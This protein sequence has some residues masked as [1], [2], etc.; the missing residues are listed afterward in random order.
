M[1]NGLRPRGFIR[2]NDVCFRR[3]Q[4]LILVGTLPSALVP[5]WEVLQLDTQNPGLKGVQAPVV[6]LHVVVVLLCLSMIANHANLLCQF[7]VVSRDNSRFAARAQILSGI[8]AKG[9]RLADR[10]N[11]L[12][13]LVTFGEI[14]SAVG[15]AGI[16]DD[17]QA[18]A[19]GNLLDCVHLGTLSIQVYGDH[20]RYRPASL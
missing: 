2:P 16:L 14:L 6:A 3:K 10:T 15:L 7:L 12:P 4:F 18:V 5:A 9:S 1:I 11:L 13:T 20:R 19:I 17:D 8:E